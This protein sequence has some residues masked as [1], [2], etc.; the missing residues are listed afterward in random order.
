MI[1]KKHELKK[2]SCK[3]F[4]G[5]QPNESLL[6][7]KTGLISYKKNRI[8]KALSINRMRLEGGGGG[9]TSK[10]HRAVIRIKI[11]RVFIFH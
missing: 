7:I 2:L 3:N 6:N 4:N 1:R 9:G 11:S 10:Y 5:P 8:S